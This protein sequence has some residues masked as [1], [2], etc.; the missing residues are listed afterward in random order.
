MKRIHSSI[1]QAENDPAYNQCPENLGG[2]TEQAMG[3]S[4]TEVVGWC[5]GF[6]DPWALCP[7]DICQGINDGSCQR[8]GYPDPHTEQKPVYYIHVIYDTRH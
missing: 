7:T 8:V 1:S 5:I 3:C 2:L 4:D 6:S